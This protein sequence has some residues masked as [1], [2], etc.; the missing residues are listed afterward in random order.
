MVTFVLAAGLLAWI[1]AVTFG[2]RFRDMDNQRFDMAEY[3]IWISLLTWTATFE[4]DCHLG[5]GLS[6]F[7][8]TA[9]LET[10]TIHG[11]LHLQF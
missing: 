10:W 11:W 4:F 3:Y 6:H 5:H 2:C 8:L 7:S 1:V 9:S